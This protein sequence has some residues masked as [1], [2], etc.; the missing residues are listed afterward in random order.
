MFIFQAIGDAYGAAFEF[1]EKDKWQPNNGLAYY[2]H[3]VIGIGAG[4]YTDDT[5]MSIA[6]MEAML[7]FKNPDANGITSDDFAQ[8]FFEVYKRNPRP[9]YSSGFTSILEESST[10]VEMLNRID[11][12]STRSGA[13]MRS[14]PVGFLKSYDRV[15]EV[16]AM[17]CAITHNTPIAI[18]A[19]QAIS[20][21]MHYLI[22]LRGTCDGIG[23]FLNA[24]LGKKFGIDWN[25]DRTEWASIEAV[26]CA[27]NAITALRTSR[28]TTEV[29]INSVEPGGDTDTVASIAMALAWASRQIEDDKSI[30]LTSELES[31]TYGFEF[32]YNLTHSASERYLK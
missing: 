6:V 18:Y 9:G 16:S 21:T 15:L 8:S 22:H 27:R 25:E 3:P 19:S 30:S 11:G 20:L 32:L 28:T 31:G 5:Q 4:R 10:Y 23:T 12:K 29:L 1:M 7:S 14:A 26:D 24:A 17:Q 13:I 2:R